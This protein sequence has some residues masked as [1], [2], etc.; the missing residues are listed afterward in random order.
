MQVQRCSRRHVWHVAGTHLCVNAESCG[1]WVHMAIIGQFGML[2]LLW[3]L[4][5]S[6][7]AVHTRQAY[8]K[9]S[10]DSHISVSHLLM[11]TQTSGFFVGS[12]CSNW[13]S[14][15]QGQCLTHR[16]ISLVYILTLLMSSMKIFCVDRNEEGLLGFWW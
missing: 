2:V 3:G 14:C 16:A 9:V 11:G 10:E 12:G 7:A 15:L 6:L 8:L 4:F 5:V 13:A 1:L